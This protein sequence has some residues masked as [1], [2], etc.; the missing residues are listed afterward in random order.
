MHHRN[1]MDAGG[2]DARANWHEHWCVAL[3]VRQ[4]QQASACKCN[5]CGAAA[6]APAFNFDSRAG[7]ARARMRSSRA[8]CI[9]AKATGAGVRGGALQKRRGVSLRLHVRQGQRLL[10]RIACAAAAAAAAAAPPPHPKAVTVTREE[11]LLHTADL[12]FLVPN[13]VQNQLPNPSVMTQVL[14]PVPINF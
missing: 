10:K 1:E 8:A 11:E 2:V 9:R 3:V 12:V 7:P 14:N 4:L 5:H 13:P 6:W